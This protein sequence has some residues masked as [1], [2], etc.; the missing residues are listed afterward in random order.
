M[1]H[2]HLQGLRANSL[3]VHHFRNNQVPTAGGIN[4]ISF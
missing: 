1:L 3:K 4:S 2:L